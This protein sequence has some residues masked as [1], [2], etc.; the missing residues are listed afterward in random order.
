M[1]LVISISDFQSESEGLNPLRRSILEYQQ[2]QISDKISM[3]NDILNGLI[4][5]D[6]LQQSKLYISYK[7]LIFIKELVSLCKDK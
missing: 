6:S 3:N 4:K 7:I 1:V 2:Q 5:I